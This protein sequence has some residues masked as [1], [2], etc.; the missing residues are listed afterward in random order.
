MS[1]LSGNVKQLCG[2]LNQVFPGGALFL[3]ATEAELKRLLMELTGGLLQ[4]DECRHVSAARMI[5]L[6]SFTDGEDSVWVFSPEVIIASNGAVLNDEDSPVLWLER[7]SGFTNALIS[8]SLSCSIITPLDQGE[9]LLDLCQAIQAFMPENFIPAVVMACSIMGASYKH[10][11]A[12]SGSMGVPFLFGEPGTCKSE[13]LKCGLALFGAQKTHL[14]NNQTTPSFLFDMLKRTTIPIGVDDISEKTQDTW[15]EL[16]IDTYNNTP[17]GTRSYSAE[18]FQS[19]PILTANWRF[20]PNRQRAHTRCVTIPFFEH[21]DEPEATRL[22]EALTKARTHVSKSVSKVIEICF[23][24]ATEAVQ[25]KQATEIF[26]QVSQILC[27]AHVRFKTTC[28]VFM[29]FFLE[30]RCEYQQNILYKLLSITLE[31]LFRCQ[32]YAALI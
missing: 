13:A 26:P 27:S 3:V 1:E 22:Y 6:N 9:A 20:N 19:T 17:R 8:D 15:E 31:L 7:P 28:T 14:Y 29:Y 23:N 16:V 10:V 24:F 5:G 18:V 25:R 30:V 12:K 11:I 4:S 2:Y 32:N 21:A